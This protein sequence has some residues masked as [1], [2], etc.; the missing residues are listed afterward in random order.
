MISGKATLVE[1]DD[2]GS[3]YELDP[4]A[5]Q[6]GQIYFHAVISQERVELVNE[7][8]RVTISEGPVSELEAIRH[9]G[10]RVG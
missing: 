3:L 10:Y 5:F 1:R 6:D 2:T 4:P 9:L 8:G 7:N